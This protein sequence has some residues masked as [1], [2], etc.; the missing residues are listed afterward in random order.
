MDATLDYLPMKVAS[1]IYM[2]VYLYRYL[3]DDRGEPLI[4][5]IGLDIWL[6]FLA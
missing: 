6:R 2:H 1:R 4:G 5:V 3:C